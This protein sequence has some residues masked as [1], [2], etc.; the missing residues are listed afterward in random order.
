MKKIL[1]D[2]DPGT[3]DA[4]AIMLAV[5]SEE[6]EVVGITTVA[7]N[8]RHTVCAQN[9]LRILELCHKTHIPVYEGA[10]APLKRTLNFSDTYCGVDG[11]GESKLPKP[12]T[13]VQD[14]N[15]IDFIIEVV[16]KYKNL[17]IV[18]IAPMTNLAQ[19]IQKAPHVDW[20][21]VSIVT[22]AGY[23][24][25]LGD[26]FVGRP[27]CEWNVLV[28]P[29]AFEI[30]IQSGMQFKALGLDVTAQLQNEMIEEV[31]KGASHSP[32]LQ[33]LKDAID[34][35]LRKGLKPY[36]LLVDA[37][38]MAYM[39]DE[40]I[41]EFESGRIEIDCESP[42]GEDTITFELHPD[43]ANLQIAKS[44]NFKKYIQLLRER[45]FFA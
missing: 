15:A 35:N 41:A 18:S 44:F 32:R 10:H 23:Y 27:R 39:I 3:D 22:M 42:L 9:A 36:S 6:I 21:K 33:S 20:S 8:A 40:T 45:V 38:P 19:A 26:K 12:T 24:K 25:I 7:G 4:L 14:Q 17:Q 31:L 13:K 37:M 11:L 43:H 5:Y 29:E 1:I 28:D 2:C 16:S 30:V 34:F